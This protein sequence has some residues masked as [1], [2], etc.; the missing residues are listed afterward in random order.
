MDHKKIYVIMYFAEL[1]KA[2]C[3][4]RGYNFI[5][6][7]KALWGQ[8]CLGDIVQTEKG[9][10]YDNGGLPRWVIEAFNNRISHIT[11][12]THYYDTTH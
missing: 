2:A 10:W 1:G 6:D 5:T 8:V 9:A 7:D 11:M 12:W 4:D 3:L